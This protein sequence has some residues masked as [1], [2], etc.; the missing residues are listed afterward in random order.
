MARRNLADCP[1]TDT[2]EE[3]ERQ[4]ETSGDNDARFQ[5][6]EEILHGG[7][8]GL[9]IP[10]TTTQSTAA[11]NSVHLEQTLQPYGDEI[12]SNVRSASQGEASDTDGKYSP[13]NTGLEVSAGVET[14]SHSNGNATGGGQELS[15]LGAIILA[16]IRQRFLFMLPSRTT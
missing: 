12:S 5:A 13:E 10:K 8:K 7:D 2:T 9:A 14:A 16:K 1:P 11:E 6:Q 4:P 3:D 15:Q